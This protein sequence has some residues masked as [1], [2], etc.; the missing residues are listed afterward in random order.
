MLE[1]EKYIIRRVELDHRAIQ[2]WNEYP[3]CIPSIA[4]LT[5]LDLH[6]SATFL[7]GENGAGKSTLI[8]AIA[9]LIGISTSG[10]SKN[11]QRDSQAHGPRLS[12]ALRLV[13]G[14]KREDLGYFLRAETMFNVSVEAKEYWPGARLSEM[15]HGESFLWLAMNYFKSPGI[16]ILDEPEAALSPQR[17][18]AFL[19]RIHQLT[20]EGSQFI[21]STHSPILLA[22]PYSQIYQLDDQGISEAEYENTDPFTITQAVVTNRQKMMQDLLENQ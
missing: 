14:A 13:R 9:D 22:Y 19:A 11:F 5:I 21:I 3:F 8:E 20:R 7:I 18:L 15:S 10:G 1:S 2:D 17:Q 16:Y 12:E 4:K 6:Q